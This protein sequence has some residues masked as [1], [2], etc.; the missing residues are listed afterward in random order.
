MPRG[1][2][3]VASCHETFKE[4]LIL[5]LW[6]LP[7]FVLQSFWFIRIKDENPENINLTQRTQRA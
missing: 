5:P 4:R 2:S 7:F 6:L 3:C 1:L